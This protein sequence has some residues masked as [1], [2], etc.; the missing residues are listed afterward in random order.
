MVVVPIHMAFISNGCSSL[1]LQRWSSSIPKWFTSDFFVVP[2]HCFPGL[3]L[4]NFLLPRAWVIVFHLI[5]KKWFGE[6][7]KSVKLLEV[8]F[9]LSVIFVSAFFFWGEITNLSLDSHRVSLFSPWAI[10]PAC[11]LDIVMKDSPLAVTHGSSPE[12]LT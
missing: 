6:G 2:G 9:D 3:T 10:A 12:E 4:I 8:Y 7:R 5:S 11:K 1:S